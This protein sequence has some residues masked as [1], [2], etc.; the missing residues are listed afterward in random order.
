MLERPDFIATLTDKGRFSALLRS[1][2]V[3]VLIG[4]EAALLGAA[5]VA[6]VLR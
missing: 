3:R 6:S 2:P 1:L 5:H 4:D